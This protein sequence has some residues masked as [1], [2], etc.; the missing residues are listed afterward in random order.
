MCAYYTF[1]PTVA[2]YWCIGVH[3]VIYITNNI[4]QNVINVVHYLSTHINQSQVDFDKNNCK[5]TKHTQ[6]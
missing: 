3:C 5:N 6:K 2:N 4:L 1:R